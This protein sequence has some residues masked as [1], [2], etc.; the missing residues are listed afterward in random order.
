MGFL[1]VSHVHIVVLAHGFKSGFASALGAVCFVC[2]L[3]GG[4]VTGF[5][6]RRVTLATLPPCSAPGSAWVW[7]PGLARSDHLV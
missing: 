7:I 6:C 3:S 5:A 4:V 2:T 1:G